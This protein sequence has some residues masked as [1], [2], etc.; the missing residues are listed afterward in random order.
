MNAW[1]QLWS[2]LFSPKTCDWI[3]SEGL[4]LPS[5]PGMVGHGHETVRN[6]NK[7]LSTIRW[8][9]REG[10][11]AQI[12]DRSVELFQEA[13]YNAFGFD[14]STLRE[15][16]FTEY[17]A[18]PGG[19]Q[20]YYTWHEDLTWATNTPYQRK[21][22]LVI[23]LSDPADYDGGD[24]QLQQEPPERRHLRTRGTAIVF[25]SFHSHQVTP[26][27]RGTRYSLVAW[28]EGPNFR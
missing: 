24:L 16:Q 18:R 8:V 26:V 4:K 3:I 1:W 28:H 20:D 21:L 17:Q 6:E 15:M 22:S 23:Q 14:L 9:K 25:P 7:R 11:L 5:Q 19:Q 10:R 27:T 13:N 2:G 12:W